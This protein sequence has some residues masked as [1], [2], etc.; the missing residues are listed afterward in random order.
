MNWEIVITSAITA[1]ISS[2]LFLTFNSWLDRGNKK[3]ALLFDLAFRLAN[4]RTDLVVKAA[5]L[6]RGRAQLTDTVFLAETY[7]KWITH[8]YNQGKLPAEAHKKATNNQTTCRTL[9][10]AILNVRFP[11]RHGLGLVTHNSC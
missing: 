2:G 3:K 9:A 1:S 6:S 10:Y 11:F 5:D 4:E 8:L 7:F